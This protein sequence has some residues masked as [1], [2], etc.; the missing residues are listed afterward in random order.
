MLYLVPLREQ[1]TSFSLAQLYRSCTERSES[2]LVGRHWRLS[3]GSLTA[4]LAD[5]Q[6]CRDCNSELWCGPIPNPSPDFREARFCLR[7]SLA[8]RFQPDTPEKQLD[9]VPELSCGELKREVV[10][11][12]RFP[13][14]F[15]PYSRAPL[16]CGE[17]TDL[18]SPFVDC[19][20]SGT[21]H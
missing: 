13:F 11:Y 4:M 21:I 1:P 20:Q 3:L 6:D 16:Q 9:A 18:R 2:A 10:W 8:R 5:P 14:S 7:N 15:D 12:Q 17:G 19:R